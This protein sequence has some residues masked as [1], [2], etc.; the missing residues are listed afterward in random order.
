MEVAIV[1]N[2]Y[3]FREYIEII[4]SNNFEVIIFCVDVEDD[5]I[6]ITFIN[7]DV[8]PA[9]KQKYYELPPEIIASEGDNKYF[10]AEHTAYQMACENWPESEVSIY[11]VDYLFNKSPDDLLCVINKQKY[12][13]KQMMEVYDTKAVFY[14]PD[15]KILN[16][17]AS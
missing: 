16:I 12:N 4:N 7:E 13:W 2:G 14:G 6:K 5:P 15:R 1:G 10:T 11:G 8:V 9:I 17:R 3:S